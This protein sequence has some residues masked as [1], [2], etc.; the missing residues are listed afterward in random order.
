MDY[1]RGEKRESALLSLRR[2]RLRKDSGKVFV[3]LRAA[4]GLSSPLNCFLVLRPFSVFSSYACSNFKDL[5][6]TTLVFAVAH[7]G[8]EYDRGSPALHL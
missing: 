5:C 6:S 4:R 3:E 2:G 7:S 1:P 8:D